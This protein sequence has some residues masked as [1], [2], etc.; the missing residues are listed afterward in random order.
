MNCLLTPLSTFN[1]IIPSVDQNYQLKCMAVLV[2][3]AQSIFIK[4]LWRRNMFLKLWGP[5]QYTDRF[6]LSSLGTS[7]IYRQIS[8]L[9]LLNINMLWSIFLI[10][11]FFLCVL[12][13]SNFCRETPY[14]DFL[15]LFLYFHHY[16]SPKFLLTR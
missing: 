14:L 15:N 9:F 1:K 8:A 16:L 7:A 10:A 4:S 11:P 13:A 3:T 6:Q 5:V 12:I 2:C